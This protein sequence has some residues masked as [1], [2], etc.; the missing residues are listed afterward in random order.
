M[1]DWPILPDETDEIPDELSLR[2]GRAALAK[3]WLNRRMLRTLGHSGHK[4]QAFL[5]LASA[6]DDAETAAHTT[7][8][9]AL[10]ALDD[11]R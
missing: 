8:T 6:A 9:M 5:E 11:G 4:S 1:I 7:L 3:A 2:V 10:E